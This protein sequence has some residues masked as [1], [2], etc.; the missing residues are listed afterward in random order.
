MV[1]VNPPAVISREA[2]AAAVSA[3]IGQA[4]ISTRSS[5]DMLPAAT[6]V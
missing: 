2:L 5:L 3:G 6:I 1:A 4:V